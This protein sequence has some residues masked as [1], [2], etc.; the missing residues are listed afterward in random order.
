[1]PKRMYSGQ[2][3]LQPCHN[4]MRLPVSMDGGTR[5]FVASLPKARA[6]LHENE[7]C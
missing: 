4:G 2:G 6:L 3:Y 5:L 7:G 1:M